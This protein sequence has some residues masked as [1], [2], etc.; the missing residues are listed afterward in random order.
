MT[1]PMQ[2]IQSLLITPA[3]YERIK[4]FIKAK[5]WR[6][7]IGKQIINGEKL[8]S[9]FEKETEVLRLFRI[10]LFNK[11]VK[12]VK[13]G[14]FTKTYPL[15]TMDSNYNNSKVKK[16]F[17]EM[18]AAET[19][20]SNTKT[21]NETYSK[22]NYDYY[23]NRITLE[24]SKMFLRGIG[25]VKML[26]KEEPEKLLK[27]VNNIQKVGVM[28]EQMAEA[29]LALI[30]N[31]AEVT[32]AVFDQIEAD[33]KAEVP[34]PDSNNKSWFDKLF[35][36]TQI[37]IAEPVKFVLVQ[38]TNGSITSINGGKR[39]SRHYRNSKSKKHRNKNKSRRRL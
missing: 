24:F 23:F 36:P 6:I 22:F 1:E 17:D 5:I 35:G 3:D 20:Q 26:L 14:D 2:K 31:A 12:M 10:A 25:Y 8:K 34:E 29:M 30:N 11:M 16:I 39:I 18:I 4:P 32:N 33:A 37:V 27:T 7:R 15:I 21:K 19:E 38:D 28:S 9:L 13:M